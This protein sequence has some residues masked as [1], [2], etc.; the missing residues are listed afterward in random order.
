MVTVSIL[1]LLSIGLLFLVQNTRN[2]E[3]H[4]NETVAVKNRF[5]TPITRVQNVESEKNVLQIN[6]IAMDETIKGYC[7]LNADIIR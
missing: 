3:N 7:R 1:I 5:N 6:S 2:T 4:E